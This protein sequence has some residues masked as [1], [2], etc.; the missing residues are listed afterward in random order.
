MARAPALQWVMTVSPSSMSSPPKR[1]MALHISMSARWISLARA[2]QIPAS[3]SRESAPL[4]CQTRR[5]SRT[6]QAR[7]TAVGRAF[8]ISVSRLSRAARQSASLAR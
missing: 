1:P 5:I 4:S 3:P 6:A 2:S 8:W 7:F